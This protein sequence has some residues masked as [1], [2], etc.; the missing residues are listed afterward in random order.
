MQTTSLTGG[1]DCAKVFCDEAGGGF[2][3]I[4][5]NPIKER[6]ISATTNKK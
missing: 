5:V 3:F 2:F 4:F 1:F 6:T